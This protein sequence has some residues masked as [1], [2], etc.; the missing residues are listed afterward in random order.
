LHSPHVKAP[1]PTSEV[2]NLTKITQADGC[3]ASLNLFGMIVV[4]INIIIVCKEDRD[5]ERRRE[6]EDEERERRDE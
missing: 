2:E 1:K 6:D 3:N 4:G 5:D